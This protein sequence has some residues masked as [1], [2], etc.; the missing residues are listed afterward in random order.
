MH[1]DKTLDILDV[2]TVALGENFR[3]FQEDTCTAFKTKELQWEADKRYREQVAEGA[4]AS[5]IRKPKGFNLNTYKFHSL[6][7]YVETIRMY[8]T[9]DSYSTEPVSLT[10]T[11]S[12]LY[13]YHACLKFF[14]TGRA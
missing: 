6:G 7:D 8:G 12:I 10:A 3:F 9:T 11:F 13:R 4:P 2:V 14:V 1:S 5:S